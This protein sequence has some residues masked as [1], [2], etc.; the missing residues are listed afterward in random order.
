MPH[1]LRIVLQVRKLPKEER[2][3]ILAEFMAHANSNQSALQAMADTVS[4]A[5]KDRLEAIKVCADKRFL[6]R[7]GAT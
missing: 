1:P 6:F 5:E 7:I 4:S 3:E 2:K